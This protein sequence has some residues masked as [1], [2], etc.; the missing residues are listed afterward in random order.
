MGQAQPLVIYANGRNGP[1]EKLMPAS[2]V[3]GVFLPGQEVA[4]CSRT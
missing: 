4:A 3:T 1:K 2:G